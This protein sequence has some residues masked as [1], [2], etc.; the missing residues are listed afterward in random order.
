MK[1][2]MNMFELRLLWA[3]IIITPLLRQ[4]IQRLI[5]VSMTE[6]P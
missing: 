1:S 2:L 5:W 4:E 3:I 6:M